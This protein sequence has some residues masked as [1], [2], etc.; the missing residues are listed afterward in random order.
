MEASHTRLVDSRASLFSAIVYYSEYSSTH[1][2]FGDFANC[3]VKQS[4]MP[5]EYSS[6][7]YSTTSATQYVTLKFGSL[8]VAG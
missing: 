3:K 4:R 8:S 1:V 6:N 2:N 7:P 5:C